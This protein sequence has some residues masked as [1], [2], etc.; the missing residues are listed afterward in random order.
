MLHNPNGLLHQSV[1]FFIEAK[2]FPRDADSSSPHAV[3]VQKLGVV[4]TRL[5]TTLPGYKVTRI[6]AGQC[7]EQDGHVTVRQ[8]G[9]GA[10]AQVSRITFDVL[11]LTPQYLAKSR[12]TSAIFAAF[13]RKA[14][15]SGGL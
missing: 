8:D 12:K 3:R 11:R 15:S 1:D 5:A 13:G 9:T 6:D 2:E 10:Q 14:S 7:A 4:R